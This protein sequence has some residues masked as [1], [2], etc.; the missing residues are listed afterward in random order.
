MKEKAN[1]RL[2]ISIY[3]IHPNKNQEYPKWFI[4]H[5]IVEETTEDWI[6]NT[7]L[8]ISK[9]NQRTSGM[10][11]YSEEEY[12]RMMW[13]YHNADLIGERVKNLND[14]GKLKQIEAL[15]DGNTK[16]EWGKQSL[17]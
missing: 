14:F 2:G 6:T 4:K 13:V 8:L 7:K 10:D 17:K 12:E 9:R 1:L 15:L 5:K 3:T 11:I 16:L